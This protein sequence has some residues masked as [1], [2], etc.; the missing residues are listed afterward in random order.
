MHYLNLLLPIF[1]FLFHPGS[2][3]NNNSNPCELSGDWAQVSQ[4]IYPTGDLFSLTFA[5]DSLS[6]RDFMEYAEAVHHTYFTGEGYIAIDQKTTLSLGKKKL[7]YKG[8]KV[9]RYRISEDC[10]TIELINTKIQNNGDTYAT[11][12][13]VY[14]HENIIAMKQGRETVFYLQRDSK[15][16][17]FVGDGE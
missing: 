10:K 13:I 17:F 8:Q 2:I 9:G 3:P 4:V 16:P 7:C 6:E 12:Q 5:A 15:N 1:V 11:C 14:C